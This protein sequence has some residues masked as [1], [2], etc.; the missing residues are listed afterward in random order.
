MRPVATLIVLISTFSSA[1]DTSTSQK[2][3]KLSRSISFQK[4]C[5]SSASWM[6]LEPVGRTNSSILTGRPSSSVIDQD[7]TQRATRPERLLRR[8][9]TSVV[10]I[11][12]DHD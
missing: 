7:G 5:Q 6:R 2:A 3:L 8:Y 1:S 4:V 11:G 10:Q 12:R 9:W